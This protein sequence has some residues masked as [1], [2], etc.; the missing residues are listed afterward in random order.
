MARIIVASYMVRMPVGGY[1]S[2][3]LQWL[4]GFTRLG[5]EVWFVEKSGWPESCIDPITWTRSDDCRRGTAALDVLLARF[6]LAG[7]W[8]YVDAAG[9]YHGMSRQAIEAVFNSADLFVDHMRDCEWVE[10]SR[11]VGHRTIIDG[12]PAFT[13]A[14]MLKRRAAGKAVIEYDSYYSVGLNV[15]TSRSSAPDAGCRWRPIFDPVVM[16]LFPVT[17]PPAD[18][19]FTTIMAWEAHNTLVFD[20]VSYA[21]KQAE[22]PKI[23]DLPSRSRRATFELAMSGLAPFDTLTAAGWRVQESARVT[24]DYDA[25]LAYILGSRG[26]ISVCKEYFVSTNSGAFSDRSA[27]YLACGRP[28]IVQDTGFSAHLPVGRGL[29]AFRTVDEAAAAV[30]AVM[31]DPGAHARWAREIAGDCLAADVVLKRLL[32]DVGL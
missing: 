16:D 9:A 31:T 8:C 19:P 32:D 1:H 18:A 6:G 5:H 20:G 23:M 3:M 10:E 13:Q 15:G 29:F 24:A 4:L 30:D 17:P 2:W 7:R 26:E 11:S 14:R 21:S 12:E 27:A 25:W 22:F 28:A